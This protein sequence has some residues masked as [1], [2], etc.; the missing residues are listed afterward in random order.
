MTW[1]RA[2]QAVPLALP[3]PPSS[4][5]DHSARHRCWCAVI[6]SSGLR[7]RLPSSWLSP[8]SAKRLITPGTNDLLEAPRVSQRIEAMLPLA[9]RHGE[10]DP[11]TTGLCFPTALVTRDS[12]FPGGRGS[13]STGETPARLRPGLTRQVWKRRGWGGAVS[14]PLMALA[15]NSP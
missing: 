8:E 3:H 14:F 7:G 5:R 10:P 6:L 9:F 2:P 13:L 1:T 11:P 12:A 15:V 4:H